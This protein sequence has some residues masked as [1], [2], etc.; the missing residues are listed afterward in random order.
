MKPTGWFRG[1]IKIFEGPEVSGDH[2]E[3][4]SASR[5]DA[6]G[7]QGCLGPS[8]QPVLASHWPGCQG[9]HTSGLSRVSLARTE[10]VCCTPT[11]EEHR[12]QAFPFVTTFNELRGCYNPFLLSTFSSLISAAPGD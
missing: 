4:P 10:P 2:L 7:P 8:R 1:I 6:Q 5:E 3:H 9:G 12:Q 11:R